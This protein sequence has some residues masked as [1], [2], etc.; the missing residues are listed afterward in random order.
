MTHSKES[1]LPHPARLYKLLAQVAKYYRRRFGDAPRAR[2]YLK[3]RGIDDKQAL[4]IFKAG[5]CDGTLHDV[6]PFDDQVHE[7]LR[8]LGV[9]KDNGKELLRECV[10]FPLWDFKGACVG[11]YG[12]RLF[13]SEVQHLYLPGPRHGLINW[14]AA[15][16]D[17]ELVLT[18]SVIDAL[19]LFVAGIHGAVPCYGA[20][21][22]TQDHIAMLERFRPAQ[23]AI[24]FDGDG[25]G[26]RSA[27]ELATKVREH[28]RGA[29]VRIVTLAEG[30]DPNSLLVSRGAD[31]L[32]GVV[33]GSAPPFTEAPAAPEPE[34][35][36]APKAG[37]GTQAFEKTAHGF[38]LHVQDRR[39]EVKAIS[40]QGTQLRITLKASKASATDDRF[41]L[42]TIDLY[43]HRSRQWFAAL[44]AQLFEIDDITASADMRAVVKHID[45]TSSGQVAEKETRVELTDSERKEAMALL[46]RSDLME[47]ILMDF[48]AVG[49][50]GEVINKQLGYLVAVSRKLDRPLS[51]LI[52]S[53]S[54]AGKSALQDAVLG[55]VP[56]EEFLKYSR[57]TDQA[58]FYQAEDALDHKVLVIEEAAGMSGAVYSIRALQS[59]EE[60]RVAA[61]GK[62]PLSG[63]MKTE[64]YTVKARTS[65]MMTTTSPDFDEET[66]NRFIQGTVDE[67]AEMTRKVL[68]VQRYGRTLEGIAL[69]RR[70][71]RIKAVHHNAQRLLMSHVVVNPYSEKLSYPSQSL[72][73]RRDNVKYLGL[74][75][76][77]ALLH[78]HQRQKKRRELFG[79]TI[80]YI[81]A[82]LDDIA[83]ANC[84]AK[85]VL[86]R[87]RGGASPQGVRLFRLVRDML[88]NGGGERP[89]TKAF[90]RRILRE[91]TGWSDWQIRTHLGE[92]VELEYLHVRQGQFGK[93]YVYELSD[94]YLLESLPGF[95][96]TD[97]EELRSALAGGD[98]VNY[99]YTKRPP[100]RTS[101]KSRPTSSEESRGYR[102]LE[103]P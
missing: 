100:P 23:I 33:E 20:G 76:A 24:C 14:Q 97:V 22:F 57:I 89:G 86:V 13:E 87:G 79:E 25:I 99:E 55:F 49:L 11:M 60:L 78:Q 19:S 71:E 43:S 30:T 38:V 9:I 21:G 61:T 3:D 8:A 27:E 28:R 82:T 62:D 101:R 17:A 84:I 73:A 64:E 47:Q 10:A 1:S 12:R 95:G 26:Q 66:K 53:R 51:L 41:E 103:G 69:R 72:V 29:T 56:P 68:D 77:C 32:H 15:K 7:D 88:L 40:R 42:S 16:R 4:E 45:E 44:C 93:E 94:T 18:E 83:V 80:D 5:Y 37:A 46:Q 35:A 92:L 54:S 39:Y 90:T 31:A 34:E 91:H 2:E 48:E 6:L 74:I 102:N 67:S 98:R 63:K 36:P 58:L 75:E 96:L 70:A 50:A 81:E 85:E 52:E 59:G 65:V